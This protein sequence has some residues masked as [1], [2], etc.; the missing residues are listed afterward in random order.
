[1]STSESSEDISEIAEVS[2]EIYEIGRIYKLVSDNGLVYIGSTKRTLEDR[3]SGHRSNYKRYLNEKKIN[4][5][6][7]KLF[8]GG[9]VVKIE[10]IE[11]H[12][13]IRKVDLHKRE[14]YHMSLNECV[15]RCL[16]GRTK[17][18]HMKVYMATH[19]DQKKEYNRKFC[20]ANSAKIAERKKTRIL[21]EACKCDILKDSKAIHER[22]L[23]HIKN[24]NIYNTYNITINI[25][26]APIHKLTDPV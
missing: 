15:N 11:E 5:T 2:E 20:K 1:M 3:L 4:I 13:R 21:C 22:T 18:E 8:E 23:K 16:A 25:T 10:L 17:N 7:N 24:Q 14:G 6:S 12:K 9:A 19:K 26:S